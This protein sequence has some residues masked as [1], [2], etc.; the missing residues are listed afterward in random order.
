MCVHVCMC[1]CFREGDEI[2]EHVYV[3]SGLW[4]HRS[5]VNQVYVT[6]TLTL[7]L[8]QVVVVVH[9]VHLGEH[10]DTTIPVPQNEYLTVRFPP[11]HERKQE[12]IMT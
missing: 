4:S 10:R 8:T 2:G 6:L 1:A 5:I 9:N 3:P 12:L 11:V 7:T